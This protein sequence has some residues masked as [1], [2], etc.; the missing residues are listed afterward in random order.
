MRTRLSILILVMILAVGI[1]CAESYPAQTGAV[2]DMAGVLDGGTVSDIESLSTRIRDAVG[3]GLYVVTRDFLGGKD[4]QAYADGLFEAWKLGDNDTLLLMVVGEYRYELVCGLNVRVI[5]SDVRD[6][7]LATKFRDSFKKQD[8]AAALG[9][10]LPAFTQ[11]LSKVTS[12]SISTSG[13]FGQSQTVT[14]TVKPV[15][16]TV[17]DIWDNFFSDISSGIEDVEQV[18]VQSQSTYE[19][20]EKKTGISVWKLIIIGFVLYL[21]FGKKKKGKNGCG[22]LGWILG[23]VGIGS[24]LGKRR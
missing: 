2:L 15:Q 10:F 4:S 16:T 1:A 13:L 24:I 11:Q 8:Y 21:I 6:S 5:P 14:A 3:G 23:A 18:N 22:P 19:R 7:L 20:V 9:A 12:Q 17:S